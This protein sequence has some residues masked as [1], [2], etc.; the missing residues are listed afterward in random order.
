MAV[1][2][3]II[4]VEEEK[5]V[6]VS[7]K[8]DENDMGL[9]GGKIE[10]GESPYSAMVREIK[11]ETGLTVKNAF[12]L[13]KRKYDGHDTYCFYVTELEESVDKCSDFIN[14]NKNNPDEGK[15]SIR[16][17]FNTYDERSSYKDYNLEIFELRDEYMFSNPFYL[18]FKSVLLQDFMSHIF[19]LN[20][21][22]VTARIIE[23]GVK[24]SDDPNEPWLIGVSD[25]QKTKKTGTTYM[26]S[27][28]KSVLFTSHDCFHQLWGLPYIEN[29]DDKDFNFF[30]RIVV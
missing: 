28:I 19:P 25:I 24:F 17:A 21:K 8:N 1:A 16:F 6:T 20:W 22:G 26:E 5:I 14:F 12:L 11:E 4:E 27:L 18:A 9:P 30:K 10:H 29:F 13:D 23:T 15:V 3:A 7:R 2:L